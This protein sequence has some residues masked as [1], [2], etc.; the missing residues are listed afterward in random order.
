VKPFA[1]TGEQAAAIQTAGHTLLAASAGTGKTT[2]VIGKILW[3]LGFDVGIDRESG[4]PI[5][6]CP[7]ERRLGLSQIAAI[8]FTE[9]AA[10]DLKRKLRERIVAQAP[11][12]IWEIDRATV[13]TIHS[14]CADLLREHALRFGIDPGFRVLDEREARLDQ[15]E[16]IKDIVLRA[17]RR[18][19][20]GAVAL[21][22][23]H[24]LEG[25]RHTSDSVD[26]VREMLHDLRWHGDRYVRWSDGFGLSV[27]RLRQVAG[28]WTEEDEP[29]LS[30]CDTL[31]RLASEVRVEWDRFQEEENVRDFDSLILDVRRLLTG[32]EGR[33]AR[34][35]VRRRYGLLI[36]DEFQDTDAAQRDIAFAIAG[37]DVSD[38][39]VAGA[40]GAGGEAA[41]PQLF[42]VGDA[43]QSIYRFRHADISVWNAVKDRLHAG[44]ASLELTH[45]FRSDPEVV[46]FVNRV[47]EPVMAEVGQALADEAPESRVDYVELRPAR[48][49]SGL[50]EIEWLEAN[51]RLVD[52]QCGREAELVAARI[53]DVVVD[54]AQGDT[55]GCLVTD[56]D[57]GKER[58]CA[59]S[60]VAILFRDRNSLEHYE[61]ALQHYAVPY[62]L[63]GDAG[64][65]DRQEILDLLTVLKLVEN[66]RDDLAA[67]GYLRSPFVGLRDEVIARLRLD[68]RPGTLLRQARRYLDRSDWFAA[69]E[70]AAIVEIERA[71]LRAGL[72]AIEEMSALR[73]RLPTDYL[74]EEV[75]GRTG[76]RLHLMLMDQ[77]EP[78][79]A[80]IQRF[81]RLLQG[82]RDHT[83]GTFLEI[84]E[85]WESQDLGVPQ[86]PLYS[87]DDDVV[88]LSTI[89]SA[90]GLEWPVV[91]LVDNDGGFSDR[92]S[93]KFWSDRDLG[94]VLC[95]KKDERGPR[96]RRLHARAT[97]EERAEEARLLYV[98]ATRARDRL[99]IAGKTEKPKGAGAWL[100]HG[101]N[102]G[103]RRTSE[104][105]R[106]EIPPLAPEPRLD[107]L[108]EIELDDAPEPLVA[109]LRPGRRRLFRSATELLSRRRGFREWQLKYWHGVTP[110]WY[111]APDSESEDEIPGWV[112]GVVIHGVLERIQEETELAELL[113]ETIGALDSPELEGR[114]AAG[115]EYRDALERE[116]AGVV[117]S[118][119]WSWYTDGAHQRELLFAQLVGPAK[120]RVGAFDLFRPGDPHWI[121][122]FKTHEIDAD[123]VERVAGE[124]ARQALL[125]R[126]AGEALAGPA[127]VRLHFTR[128]NR[129]V[130]VN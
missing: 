17:L 36:I 26:Y 122:D 72:D 95:P 121:V 62:Y 10:Y 49:K 5:P 89:H 68:G 64:L 96:T 47:C 101:L 6:P 4:R 125:Y 84:W 74:L 22:R 21:V 54:P 110:P 11:G 105:A 103:V 14:F 7:E 118:E 57:T 99:I 12:L 66:P 73:S 104:P 88:T 39:S 115:T 16:L 1:W 50:S 38:A 119:E 98:A 32:P 78:K 94:P 31:Q 106:V 113:E 75:L 82:Y 3:H 27:E 53:R 128:P 108:D 20:E 61:K 59:Y 112:R 126:I 45:N 25:W 23:R 37:L 97:A 42:L 35:S 44:E 33:A 114:M 77:P 91:F 116:I 87:K 85:R 29:A 55:S 52:D 117:A 67:F 70:H 80:N 65:T 24:R 40:N 76:Y 34:A 30:H 107:W 41:P 123:A 69:P 48:K 130:D 51:E 8:T 79:L 56:P 15:E 63:A 83:V 100:S 129:A 90:K 71:A 60:D 18:G 93:N 86:A 92:L 46:D 102:G 109:P 111:F 28:V 81:L 124:Y 19:D 13:G 127:R 2:T 58:D 120:W 43:K 9:K